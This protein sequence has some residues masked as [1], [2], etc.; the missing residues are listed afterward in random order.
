MAGLEACLAGFKPRELEFSAHNQSVNAGL[1][2]EN[3]AA[4][5][6]RFTDMRRRRGRRNP[7]GLHRRRYD[8]SVERLH[9]R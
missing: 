6:R 8:P 3:S 1:V 4:R 5:V 7:G 2:P 9:I